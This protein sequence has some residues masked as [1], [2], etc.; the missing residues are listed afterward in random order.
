[1]LTDTELTAIRRHLTRA[2][3]GVHPGH[4]TPT[5]QKHMDQLLEHVEGQAAH[6]DAL[7]ANLNAHR[8]GQGTYEGRQT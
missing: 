3:G 8:A 1:M 7:Q 4:K 2:L 6:I 5:W